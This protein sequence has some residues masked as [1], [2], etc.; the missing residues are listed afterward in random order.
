MADPVVIVEKII[1]IAIN[2]K[3]AVE[4][5]RENKEECR[6]IEKLVR[7]ISD[8]LSLLKDSEM[9]RHKVIGG[10]LE[11][12]GDAIR[13][14]HDVV[15]ACQGKNI[16]C[17]FCKAGKLAK[18]LSQ[19]K[20]DISHG[21][22]LAIFAN[23]TAA[24]VFVATKGQQSSVTVN[25]FPVRTYQPPPLSEHLPSRPTV[26][27]DDDLQP[28]LPTHEGSFHPPDDVLGNDI[29]P[30]RPH[31]H[32]S[33][34]RTNVVAPPLSKHLPRRQP[35]QPTPALPTPPPPPPRMTRYK[36]SPPP[37]PPSPP[38][39]PPLPLPT[40]VT[41]PMSDHQPQRS[42]TPPSPP[43]RPPIANI[44]P[45]LSKHQPPS[46]PTQSSLPPPS[47][48]TPTNPITSTGLAKPGHLPRPSSH[49]PHSTSQNIADI[50]APIS[51]PVSL[52][53]SEDDCIS[54]ERK[55]KRAESEAPS[56]PLPGLTKFSL[57]ELKNATQNFSEKNKIGSNDFSTVYKGILHDRLL[58]AIKKFR[59]PPPFLVARLS[60]ELHLASEL[61]TKDVEALRDNKYIIRILGYGH[62]FMWE[63]QC[64][65]THIF[66]VEEYLPNGN[67]GNN[68]YGEYRLHWSSLF[69]IIQGLAQ[70]LKCLH[71]Q[72]IVHRNV[73]PA[74]VLLDSDMNPKITDFGIA[75]I[76]EKPMVHDNNIAGT[77]GYMPPEYILEGILSTKY[78]VYSFGVTLL[79]TISGMCRS[80]PA[81]HHA[82][83]P[84]AWNV[85]ENQQMGELF[86]QSLF[87]I[88]Q[89]TEIKRCLE[90]GLLCTQS[91]WVERPTMAEVLD[92]LSGKVVGLGTPKQPEYT[93]ERVMTSKG[94]S[95]KVRGGR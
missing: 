81:R 56:H 53:P 72:N 51:G 44:A 61:Q 62:E 2:L 24:T 11:D 18:K 77:V 31:S 34:P 41:S 94:A 76:L 27:V 49:V 87:E 75:R 79:E 14:A 36:P 42:S 32:T 16:L 33:P 60:T 52:T 93:K 23:Q 6:G 46:P 37:T 15:T 8:L 69:K 4:T 55:N 26:F 78:D 20:N 68:I 88:S 45:P 95:R 39:P 29:R 3:D 85:R 59:D 84:W 10:P 70:G 82:S 91:E 48:P 80:E 22:M 63:N 47:R 30:S 50:S 71:E 5:V 89:L 12:L 86:D 90:I 57:T 19:V 64:L 83:I 67:M 65:Q 21:M 58:V 54:D 43:R 17:L 9:M 66:L 13:R 92:M 35:R 1:D 73:K 38:P 7:R 25:V 28:S 74:I 40:Y